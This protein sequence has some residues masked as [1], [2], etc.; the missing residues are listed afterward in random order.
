MATT[1]LIRTKLH[2]PPVPRDLI[3]RPRLVGKL[4]QGLERK[5]T[6]VSA[7][8]GYGKS[9]TVS[10]WAETL[11]LPTAWLSLDEYDDDLATFG[12]YLVETVRTVYPDACSTF[13]A[14]LHATTLPLPHHLAD[15]FLVDLEKLPGPLA[16]V[17]DDYHTL[18]NPD[19]HAFIQRM[20][21]RLPA[22][23]QLVLITRL[24][25]PLD[26]PRLRAQRQ[27]L[28]ID[29]GDLAFTPEESRA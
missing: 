25:P 5:L 6:L 24:D 22:A 20:A 21:H 18:Q 19:I 14:L 8:A 11:E 3:E 23:I 13:S 29:E 9:T 7:P 1:T 17:L 26:L 10:V 16:L 28:E 27:V 12:I 15:K 2:R 4:N